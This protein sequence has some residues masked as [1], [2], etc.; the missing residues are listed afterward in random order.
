VKHGDGDKGIV[1]TAQAH[2]GR[3]SLA[4]SDRGNGV[5]AEEVSTIFD[6]FHSGAGE[7]RG[8]GLGLSIVKGFIEAMGGSVSARSQTEGGFG[9]TIVLELPLAV[10][11]A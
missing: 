4:V 5:P 3:C 10:D 9:L 6:R 8:S 11:H 1:M 2:D 7:K